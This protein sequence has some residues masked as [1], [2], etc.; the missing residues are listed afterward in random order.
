MSLFTVKVLRFQIM[1][2][3]EW[4]KKGASSNGGI[5]AI[6]DR[7]VGSLRLRGLGIRTR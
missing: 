4:L 7:V 5:Y 1:F 2:L 6:T 3:D